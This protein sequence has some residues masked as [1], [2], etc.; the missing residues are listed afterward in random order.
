MPPNSSNYKI[1]IILRLERDFMHRGQQLNVSPLFPC[2]R[3]VCRVSYQCHSG[4]VLNLRPKTDASYLKVCHQDKNCRF[5]S[6]TLKKM[7]TPVGAATGSDSPLTSPVSLQIY[8]DAQNSP[9][10][11]DQN[12]QKKIATCCALNTSKTCI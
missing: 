6:R 2:L 7:L 5:D 4:H 1:L 12:F 9:S 11:L 8:S 3:S 10:E